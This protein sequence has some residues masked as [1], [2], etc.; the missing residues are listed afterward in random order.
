M[1]NLASN[2]GQAIGN[3]FQ[4][5]WDF[6]KNVLDWLNPFSDNFILK[7]L[8]T[9]LTDIISYINPWHDN[10]LGKKI[11]EL[12]GDLLK[13]LFIPDD[14][15]FDDNIEEIK[16]KIAEKIPYQ[17]YID[18]FETIEQVNG[19]GDLSVSLE[20]YNFGKGLTYSNKK[21]IDFNWVTKYK[22]TWYAWCRGVIFILLIIYNI[23]QISK[24]F[25]GYNVGDGSGKGSVYD[26]GSHTWVKGG[27]GK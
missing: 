20:N 13:W 25:R 6:I 23:N 14:N 27:D 16:G 8:W 4:P 7:K 1:G 3:V 15:F 18:M 21:F 17:D 11:I 26:Y 5:L 24:L 9:F 22:D 19:D 2:I 12:L 10:F